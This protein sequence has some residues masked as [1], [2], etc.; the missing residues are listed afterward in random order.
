M[1]LALT[2]P[3]SYLQVRVEYLSQPDIY[4]PEVLARVKPEFLQQRYDLPEFDPSCHPLSGESLMGEKKSEGQM[5]KPV[6]E[7]GETSK[8]PADANLFLEL[9]AKKSGKLLKVI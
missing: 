9:V 2:H 8:W 6:Y 5:E 1:E 3:I 7:Y 4:I